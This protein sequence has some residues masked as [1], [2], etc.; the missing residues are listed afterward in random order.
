[1][2]NESRAATDVSGH[3]ASTKSINNAITGNM[4]KYQ[5][6]EVKG[7]FSA[8]PVGSVCKTKADNFFGGNLRT[9]F[10][11]FVISS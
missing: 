7:S 5:L 6:K 1:M 3:Y 10:H 8:S 4:V 2:S 9:K 11:L